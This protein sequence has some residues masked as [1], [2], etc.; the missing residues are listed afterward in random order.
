[1]HFRGGKVLATIRNPK[2]YGV[3]CEGIMFSAD[4]IPYKPSLHSGCSPNYAFWN[5]KGSHPKILL[6]ADTPL[7]A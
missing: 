4:I 2:R 3:T 5:D 1:M 6:S 7:R